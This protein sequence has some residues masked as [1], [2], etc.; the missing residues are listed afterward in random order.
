MRVAITEG[1]GLIGH[2]LASE[3]NEDAADPV[4]AIR[5]RV[6]GVA[7]VNAGERRPGPLR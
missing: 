4:G 7:L 1:C 3:L 2:H 5:L 6:E